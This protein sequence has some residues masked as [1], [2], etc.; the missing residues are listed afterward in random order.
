MDFDIE[1]LRR[2][3][4]TVKQIATDLYGVKWRNDRA[5]CPRGENHVNGDRDPSFAYLSK[6][7]T[8]G[9]LLACSTDESTRIWKDLR[10]RNVIALRN[11]SRF[12]THW[13]ATTLLVEVGQ[14][15]WK[16]KPPTG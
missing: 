12:Q 7:E 10:D 4:P 13:S 16:P 1:E 15:S 8:I 9:S 5:T 3:L 11:K 14:R 6:T 2:R